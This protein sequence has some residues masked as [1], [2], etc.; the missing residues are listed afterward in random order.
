MAG[1]KDGFAVQ[2]KRC[3]CHGDLPPALGQIARHHLLHEQR[4]CSHGLPAELLALLAGVANEKVDL[5]GP[6]IGRIDLTTVLPLFRSAP[7]SST[8]LPRHSMLCS[9]SAKAS[10]IIS[11]TERARGEREIVG[12]IRLQDHVHAF[13][14]VLGNRIAL[15]PSG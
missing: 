6:E 4:K 5:D 14:I 2:L 12:L 1:D 7:V 13:I 10:S 8:P 15:R 3:A 11:R 9:T